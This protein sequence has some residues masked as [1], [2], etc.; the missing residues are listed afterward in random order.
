[1]VPWYV[2]TY[3][4]AAFDGKTP[5]SPASLDR[6][7]ELRRFYGLELNSSASHRL[8]EIKGKRVRKRKV[9]NDRP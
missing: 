6:T 1:M 8:K 2:G 9:E 7:Q 4:G 3:V 5:F